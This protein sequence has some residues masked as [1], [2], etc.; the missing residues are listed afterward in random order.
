MDRIEGEFQ[1]EVDYI[2]VFHDPAHTE[3]FAYESYVIPK[4]FTLGI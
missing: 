4:F 3:K 2:G 1:I